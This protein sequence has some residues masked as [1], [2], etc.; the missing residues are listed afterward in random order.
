MEEKQQEKEEKTACEDFF[1]G[2][3]KR[4]KL[5]HEPTPGFTFENDADIGRFI[6]GKERMRIDSSGNVGIGTTTP[7]AKL[8]VAF[9]S[10]K[11]LKFNDEGE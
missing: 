10:G 8:H 1:D 9:P 11:E 7:S 3:E 5:K 4:R 6:N 2:L